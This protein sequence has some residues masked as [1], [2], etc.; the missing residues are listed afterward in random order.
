MV[1]GFQDIMASIIQGSCIGP[2]SYVVTAS[3]LHPVTAGNS[4][5]KYADDTYL[6]VPASNFLSRESE[7]TNVELWAKEN[8]LTLNR[9]KS[10]EIVFVSARCRRDLV[11]PPSAH[12]FE[13]VEQIKALGV[14]FTRKLSVSPHIEELLCDMRQNIIRAEDSETPWPSNRCSSRHFPG[15]R[16]RQANVRFA[17]LAWICERRRLC[18]SGGISPT[19][20]STRLPISL[21]ADIFQCVRRSR[22]STLLEHHQRPS[23]SSSVI[24]SANTQ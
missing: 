8:N 5:H 11:V 12:G 14:T 3:D 1:S 18:S 4:M 19:F 2:A 16:R 23:A 24:A 17:G 20:S 13:R 10:A 6:V 15:N 21:S 7:V 22:R 9:V